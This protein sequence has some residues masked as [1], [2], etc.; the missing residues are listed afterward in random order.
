MGVGG[1]NKVVRVPA[2]L[3]ELRQGKGEGNPQELNPADSRDTRSWSF[4]LVWFGLG[5]FWSHPQH[6]VMPRPESK[7]VPQQQPRPLQ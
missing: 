3:R 6:V 7:P 5:F 4:G 1:V 2:G